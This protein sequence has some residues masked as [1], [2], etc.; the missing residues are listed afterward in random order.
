ML[1]ALLL[2]AGLLA[3]P[4]WHGGVLLGLSVAVKPYTAVFLPV[5]LANGSLGTLVA[6][7]GVA[8]VGWLPALWWGGFGESLAMLNAMQGGAS[9]LRYLAAPL[10]LGALR[11]PLLACVAFVALAMTSEV[12]GL[13]YLVPLVVATGILLEPVE[14]RRGAASPVHDGAG[15]G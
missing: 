15:P 13:G 10:T 2:A 14:G 11:V 7:L 6:A 8:A 5:A 12:W 1:P 4:S 9:P 3:L